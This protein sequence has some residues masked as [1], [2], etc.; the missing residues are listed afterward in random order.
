MNTALI[1]GLAF[2]AAQSTPPPSAMAWGSAVLR[3]KPA[4]YA[5]TEARA[6]ADTVLSYQ[7]QQGA[8][9]KNTDMSKALTPTILAQIDS[10]GE[11]DTIDNGATTTPMR[12]FAL[13][14]EAAPEAR[15]RDAFERGME[16]LLKSQYP[17]GGFPQF[18]PLREGYYS[19]ITYN[20]DATVNVLTL[21]RDVAAG[22][23]PFA[24][25]TPALKARSSAA[26][27]RGIEV[28]LKTQLEQEGKLTAW[29]AQYDEKTLAPAWARKYEPPSLSGNESVGLTRFLMEI[30]LPTPEIVASVEGAVAWLRSVAIAGARMEPFVDA[31]GKKD[32]RIVSDASAP[33]IWA[34]FYEL[35]TN[36][37]IFLGRDSVVHY[38]LSEIESERR[39]GYAYYGVWPEALLTK[40]YPRWRAKQDGRKPN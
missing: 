36:R 26:V 30:E 4:W 1:L 10:L 16:Y 38:A 11:A 18:F 40:D 5:T 8:W 35:R 32:R 13:M 7:S 28:I 29:C 34:R 3:Q 25:V 20:D 6:L 33:P 21:L 9:P 19:H 12:F 22:K 2:S 15:Y 27:S 14:N 17:N 37:P 23:A 39:N 31:D 24:F